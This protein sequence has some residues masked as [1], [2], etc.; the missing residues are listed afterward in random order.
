VRQ[1]AALI[2]IILAA[3]AIAIV[4]SRRRLSTRSPR[5]Q[6]RSARRSAW[7]MVAFFA[8]MVAQD[9]MRNRVSFWTFWVGGCGLMMLLWQLLGS[10]E[11]FS[12]AEATANY[13]A[14]RQHCG[15]CE[16]DLTGNQSGVCPECGWQIPRDVRPEGRE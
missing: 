1:S 16:Y 15:R 3:W 8:F 2:I 9:L 10:P 11:R 14:D 12:N 6:R 4:I 5:R 13:A 7:V